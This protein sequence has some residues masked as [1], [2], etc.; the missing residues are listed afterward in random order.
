MLHPRKQLLD[1]R[2]HHERDL[3]AQLAQFKS[4][5]Q[6]RDERLRKLTEEYEKR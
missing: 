2:A 5:L 3:S 1:L 6:E 4:E